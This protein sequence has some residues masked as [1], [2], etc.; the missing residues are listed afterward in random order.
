MPNSSWSRSTSSLVHG[1][2]AAALALSSTAGC[3]GNSSASTAGAAGAGAISSGG[4]SS[5]GSSNGGGAQ[6]GG[7]SNSAGARNDG[8]GAGGASTTSGGASTTSGGASTT[9]GGASTTSGGANSS[10]G[11]SGCSQLTTQAECRA[12]TDCYAIVKPI[13]C[14]GSGV[15][16]PSEFTR[17]SDTGCDP[18]CDANSV[19]VSQQISGGAV[20]M[21]DDA[22]A[23]PI[24]SHPTG[25]NGRCDNNPSYS[26]KATPAA[27]GSTIDCACAQSLCS[28]LCQEASTQ[29]ISCVEDVP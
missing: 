10:G 3:G 25:S 6:N 9:S 22:G 15:P 19:C 23:C 7:A 13:L 20:I 29:Q 27:C 5:A 28:G 8:A 4:A 12:R 18:A 14:P 21:E 17:C 11:N 16:C 2:L 24:G 26:C 1:A